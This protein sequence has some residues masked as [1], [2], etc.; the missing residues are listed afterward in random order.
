[1]RMNCRRGF[2]L[3]ELLVVIAIIG[4]LIALL[5]PA[6]QQAREA[7]RRMQCSNNLKQ[8]G[9]ALHNYH[10]TFGKFP[11]GYL[12][13]DLNG[14]NLD[15]NGTGSSWGWGAQLLPFIEQ[16]ALA[17][18]LGVGSQSLT[19]AL[20]NATLVTLMKQP[21]QAF[22]CPSDTA[23]NPNTGHQL[24]KSS[25]DEPVAT[26]N[27]VG[28]NTSHKWHSG[29]RLTGYGPGEGGGWSGP[30]AA[31]APT[32]IFWRNSRIGMR[33]ITDGTS[34]T[35]AIGERSW[36][37]NNPAGTQFVC[38]AA[39][40]IGTAHNNEQLTIRHVLAG[41]AVRINFTNNECKYG[42]SSRHPGG[43]MFVLCDGSVRF[44]PETID[45]TPTASGSSGSFNNSTFEKLLSRDDGQPIGS[46]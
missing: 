19:N 12:L 41:G 23:P 2:T 26:S 22:L 16:N 33:D 40:A 38:D 11:P 14:S 39:I 6:V 10:D 45:H 34:N 7:A 29:G 8:F 3:V 17:D 42:F 46:Y 28:N 31:N 37:L 9:I 20:S 27:Y 5:L 13:Q 43:A 4:V 36:R 35:I 25:G 30:G 24:K 21:V 32:G 1:M 18:S 15:Y 44:I